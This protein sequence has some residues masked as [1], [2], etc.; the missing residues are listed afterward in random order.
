MTSLKVKGYRVLIEAEKIQE[1]SAGGIVLTATEN[2]KR[3]E[4]HGMYEGRVVQVGDLAFTD[5]TVNGE[6]CEPWCKVGDM[7]YW[8]RYAGKFLYDPVTEIE[9]SVVND[10]D[11]ICVIEEA[12]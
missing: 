1:T 4:Q 11:I 9:Y 5:K 2:Q 8:A 12:A 10:E 3:L 7:V 6:P